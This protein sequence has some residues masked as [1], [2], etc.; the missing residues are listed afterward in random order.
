MFGADDALL[1]YRRLFTRT[2]CRPAGRNGA[3]VLT[4]NGLHEQFY[5]EMV[6]E[7]NQKYPDR[8]I[9]LNTVVYPY[10]QMHDNL[11]VSLIAGEGFPI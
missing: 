10:G 3:D 7:W 1:V 4:F 8:K 6:K 9:K 2:D 11:S 5:Q